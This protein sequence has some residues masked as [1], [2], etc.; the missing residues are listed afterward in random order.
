MVSK[1]YRNY[2]IVAQAVAGICAVIGGVKVYGRMMEGSSEG[3]R[4]ILVW[5]SAA[6]FCLF[7]FPIL[8]KLFGA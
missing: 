4:S 6:L 1:M 2:K 8:D 7:I 5:F 3:R